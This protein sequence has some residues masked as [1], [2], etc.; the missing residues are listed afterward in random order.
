MS[1]RHSA[2]EAEEEQIG[3]QDENE[4]PEEE[5]D[6]GEELINDN[7]AADYKPIP[8]LDRYEEEGLDDDQDFQDMNY[9]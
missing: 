7:M 1:E 6:S 9:D 4:T 5:E 3:L 8:E 2:D